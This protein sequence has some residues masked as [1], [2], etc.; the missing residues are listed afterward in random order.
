MQSILMVYSVNPS[1]YE[2]DLEI[3]ASKSSYFCRCWSQTVENMQMNIFF[4][5]SFNVP[6][7]D[8]DVFTQSLLQ[9][10]GHDI[11]KNI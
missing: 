1:Q 7:I 11:F 5:K 2:N 10:K 9:Q 3:Y 4:R 8:L 6:V